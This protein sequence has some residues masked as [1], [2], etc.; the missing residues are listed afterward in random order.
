MRR[1]TLL[2]PLTLVALVTGGASPARPA[3]WSDARFR[4]EVTLKQPRVPRDAPPLTLIG[5]GEGRIPGE[6]VRGV[7][8][9]A[10]WVQDVAEACTRAAGTPVRVQALWARRHV[11]APAAPGECREVME[12]LRAALGG[13]WWKSGAVWILADTLEEVRLT[14]L[15]REQRLLEK[16][17]AYTALF[18]ALLERDWRL[19]SGDRSVPL[20]ALS[21]AAQR[22]A[23]L[24]VRLGAFAD[25]SDA[26]AR[27]HRFTER[28]LSGDLTLQLRGSGPTASLDI[29][30]RGGTSISVPFFHPVSGELLYGVPPPR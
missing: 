20:Q 18:A 16:R 13:R 2:L 27:E 30:E 8:V 29:N 11:V 5:A 15:S 25:E 21:T 24:G 3:F 10:V 26:S 23:M 6:P 19:L 28:A 4:S 7:G 17:R 12:G 9:A 22:A 1:S 14:L